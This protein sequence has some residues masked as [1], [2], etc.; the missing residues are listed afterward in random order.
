MELPINFD[1]W[2]FE[3]VAAIERK[4]EYEPGSFD[5]KGILTLSRT[6]SNKGEFNAS[7][8]RTVCAMA[9]ADGGFILFGVR[10]RERAVN[11]PDERIV[12]IPLKGDL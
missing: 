12:G 7:L 6:D 1:A 4:Y 2:N 8:R 10:D 11:S 5:Y 9:N 3:L